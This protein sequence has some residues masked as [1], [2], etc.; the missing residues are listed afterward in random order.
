VSNSDA[1]TLPEPAGG[2]RAGEGEGTG[3]S[4]SREGGNRSADP[5][6]SASPNSDKFLA[7][8]AAPGGGMAPPV[9]PEV[10]GGREGGGEGEGGEGLGK[11][12]LPSRESSD[13]EAKRSASLR[14][15]EEEGGKAEGGTVGGS[16]SGRSG[17]GS[18]ARRSPA[19]S[20]PPPSSE[21]AAPNRLEVAGGGGAP[22]GLPQGGRGRVFSRVFTAD[23][24]YVPEEVPS[25]VGG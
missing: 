20:E 1:F 17:E 15:E 10:E 8:E 3:P 19:S 14:A 13:S 18:A 23:R 22:R 24:V 5:S 11:R 4:G 7:A 12:P 21:P 2:T 9:T 16:S 25:L 6:E